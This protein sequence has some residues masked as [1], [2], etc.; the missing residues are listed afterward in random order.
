MIDSVTLT[1][2]SGAAAF[3]IPA[4]F[5]GSPMLYTTIIFPFKAVTLAVQFVVNPVTFTI[6]AVVDAVTLIIQTLIK[7]ITF[8]L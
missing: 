2:K 4:A 6:Q 3:R 7:A 8:G 1:I 5:V